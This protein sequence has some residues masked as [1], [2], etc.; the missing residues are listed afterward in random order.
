VTAAPATDYWLSKLFFD[1]QR[2]D[3]AARYRAD[4]D[5][6]LAEY[7]LTPDV[8]RALDANDVATLAPLVN[9]YLLRYYFGII[10]LPDET[11]MAKLRETA[12][13]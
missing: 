8:R 5:A 1:I 4:R 9:A 3:V 2:P 13:G 12:H 6:L 7:R 10:G 11:F